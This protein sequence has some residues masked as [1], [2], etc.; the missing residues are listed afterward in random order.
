MS[1][2]T[3]NP[4]KSEELTRD[5]ASKA[6]NCRKKATDGGKSCSENLINFVGVDIPVEKLVSNGYEVNYDEEIVTCGTN[7]GSPELYV[8]NVR[9]INK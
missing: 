8:L 7:Y 9:I 5:S 1:D 4:I 6:D 3:E 2:P